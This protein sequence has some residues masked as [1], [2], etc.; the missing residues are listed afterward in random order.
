M[1]PPYIPHPDA[2]IPPGMVAVHPHWRPTM[3]GQG[4]PMWLYAADSPEI[5]PCSCDSLPH[6]DQHYRLTDPE[7]GRQ[8]RTI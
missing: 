5:E 2:K 8:W 6:V 1:H 3:I 4:W 7:G